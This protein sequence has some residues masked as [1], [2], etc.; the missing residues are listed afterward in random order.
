[1][2]TL[3]FISLLIQMVLMEN[4]TPEFN[5]HFKFSQKNVPHAH[6]LIKVIRK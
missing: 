5:L 2:N 3:Q 6:A 1:M 4:G